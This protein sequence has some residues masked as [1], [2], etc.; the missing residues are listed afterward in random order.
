[1][2]GEWVVNLII[3]LNF[4]QPDYYLFKDVLLSTENGTTQ[5]DHVLFSRFGI[6]VIETKNMKGWIFGEEN[7]TKWTQQIYK[8]K[9]YFQNPVYQNFKHKRAL[10]SVLNADA[11]T[12]KSIVV[13][14]GG[15]TFKNQ[16]P[17]NV[18]YGS[19][20]KKFIK[21]FTKECFTA[22]EMTDLIAQLTEG[23]LSSNLKNK[24]AHVSM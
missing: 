2:L 13:F 17:S 16:M 12:V 3:K 6:F 8:H 7:Q 21:S 9:S 23:K 24:H 4:K 15:A 19:G 5:I 11:S 20:L 22:S 18:V 10:E 14:I 1:M